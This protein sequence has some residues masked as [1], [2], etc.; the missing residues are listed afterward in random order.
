M[1]GRILIA[2]DEF[3]VRDSLAQYLGRMGYDVDTAADAIQALEMFRA[4][5]Y[6]ILITDLVMPGASGIE[7]IDAANRIDPDVPK[8]IISGLGTLDDAVAAIRKGAYDYLE[9]PFRDFTQLT[10]TIS[11]ALEKRRLIAERRE[12]QAHL[13]ATNRSLAEHVEELEG[14]RLQLSLQAESLRDANEVIQN[15]YRLLEQDLL[16]ARRIQQ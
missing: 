14:A 4:S 5:P 2:D 13:E 16:I 9:K 12:M 8:I 1:R 11:R 3:P 6:D 15:Q 7:L 10:V